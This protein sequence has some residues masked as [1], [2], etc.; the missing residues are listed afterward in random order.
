MYL[1]GTW[2]GFAL[3]LTCEDKVLLKDVIPVNKSLY[4]LCI[5]NVV[6]A[7]AALTASMPGPAM[8]LSISCW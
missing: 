7:L 2:Y 3:S 4:S 6:Y 5:F 8:K 1:S